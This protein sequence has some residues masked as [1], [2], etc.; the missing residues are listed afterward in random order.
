MRTLIARFAIEPPLTKGS[1]LHGLENGVQGLKVLDTTGRVLCSGGP[2]FDRNSRG[3]TSLSIPRL[4]R[5]EYLL[6]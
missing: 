6:E 3:G 1:T 4:G 2:A 5:S